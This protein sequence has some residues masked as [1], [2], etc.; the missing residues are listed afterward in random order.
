LRGYYFGTIG[1]KDEIPGRYSLSTDCN[2]I[3]V[4]F[5]DGSKENVYISGDKVFLTAVSLKLTRKG[6][7]ELVSVINYILDQKNATVFVYYDSYMDHIFIG[8]KPIEAHMKTVKKAKKLLRSLIKS[9]P[10]IVFDKKTKSIKVLD[11]YYITRRG[12]I[13]TDGKTKC[14][15]QREGSYLPIY[16]EIVMKIMYLL[17]L[18]Q[19]KITEG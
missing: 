7:H 12:T 15:N 4:E 13:L 1:D 17:N 2:T 14:I 8:K 9:D 11:K 6:K 18:N 3:T 5:K 16:D 10:N 19:L